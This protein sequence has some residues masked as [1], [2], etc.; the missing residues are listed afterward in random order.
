M[1]IATTLCVMSIAV[2]TATTCES[3]PTPPTPAGKA[4]EVRVSNS[5]LVA[6]CLNGAPIDG[7]KVRDWK[8]TTPTA[9]VF[10]MKNEPRSGIEN[11]APGMAAISFTPQPGH[12][13]EI[14]VRADA[15]AF[16]K[17]VWAKG[18]WKPVVRDRTTDQIVSSEPLWVDGCK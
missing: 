9:F 5:H 11:R 8:P 2:A 4:A 17:R 18:E 12:N 6:T 14:E 3:S 7:N 1:S 15:A 13:Y 10:T 16:S